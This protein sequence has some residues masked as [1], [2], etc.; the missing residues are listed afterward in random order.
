ME[1]MK[2]INLLREL[3]VMNRDDGEAFTVGHRLNRIDKLLKK[4]SYEHT[5]DGT[6]FRIYSRCPLESLG[7]IIVISS[8]ID[9]HKNISRCYSLEEGEFLHGTYDNSITNA[10]LIHL[11][12]EE[13]LPDHVIAAFTGDEE[14]EM[15]GAIS[16]CEY[17]WKKK[18]PFKSIVLDVTFEGWENAMFTI[19]NNLW[20][21]AYGRCACRAAEKTG[22]PWMFAAYDLKHL[23]EYVP[24]AIVSEYESEEDET[25]T[26]DQYGVESFSFCIPTAGE[27]HGNEGLHVRKKVFDGYIRA[28]EMVAN[29]LGNAKEK[30]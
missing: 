3:N 27:M 19:E 2:Q 30:R 28:L 16:L 8:H 14:Y 7:E 11:M 21:D 22:L 12:M 1:E 20:S 25:W 6:L 23:P 17:L 29:E 18:I 24:A 15:G 9:V 26:Y 10:A 5:Y 4:T 13:R